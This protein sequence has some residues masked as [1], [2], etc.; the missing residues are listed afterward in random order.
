MGFF[1]KLGH[2]FK[3]LT[4]PIGNF[5]KGVGHGLSKFAKGAGHTISSV[6]KT[7]GHDAQSLFKTGLGVFK[8]YGDAG[9]GLLGGLGKLASSP[10]TLIVIGIGGIVAIQFLRK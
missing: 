10:L 4:K 9:A 1:K 5:A 3:N 6:G 2:G 7:V 8:N